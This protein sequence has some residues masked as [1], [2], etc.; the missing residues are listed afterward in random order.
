MRRRYAERASLTHL[1]KYRYGERRAF[2]RIGTGAELVEYDEG[3]LRY[4]LEHTD[5]IHHMSRK[6]RKRL[7]DRLL[8]ADIR[9][10]AVEHAERRAF[11]ARDM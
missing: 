9:H 1:F 11:R 7:F 3:V 5:D 6:R 2:D 4:R 10:Y 8:V